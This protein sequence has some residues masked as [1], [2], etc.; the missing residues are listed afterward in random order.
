MLPLVI[1][2][3]LIFLQLLFL[4]LKAHYLVPWLVVSQGFIRSNGNDIR[5]TIWRECSSGRD[6]VILNCNCSVM[7]PISPRMNGCASLG[8]KI[9]RE[10][11]SLSCGCYCF[12]QTTIL[13]VF[14]NV[15]QVRIV[16][17]AFDQAR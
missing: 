15:S 3:I 11:Q 1:Q 10:L 14:V 6:Q 7:N 5:L 12:Y 9:K 8:S 17:L 13:I 16:R 2:S 4:S